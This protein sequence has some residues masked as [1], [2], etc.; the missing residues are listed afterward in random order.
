M[1]AGSPQPLLQICQ[2]VVGKALQPP[3]TGLDPHQQ[4]MVD[5]AIGQ[6]QA[7]AVGQGG[8]GGDICLE[9][10]GEKQHPPAPQPAGQGLLQL[11]VLRPGA[12]HQPRGGGPHPAGCDGGLG[13]L[14]QG[15]MTA[16]GEGIV[17][18]EVEQG[19]AAGGR[20]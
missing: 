9:A 2:V 12:T 3:P 20:E 16:E 8:H 11:G 17:A 6:H 13:R 5:Q 4:R 1:F 19:A 15:R 18:G 14:H 7:V 10:A